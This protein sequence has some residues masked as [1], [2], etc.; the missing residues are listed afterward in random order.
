M[1]YAGVNR[2]ILKAAVNELD[3]SHYTLFIGLCFK[4]FRKSPF[5][6]EKKVGK[7]PRI[8]LFILE[9]PRREPGDV[10]ALQQ[11][12]KFVGELCNA[13]VLRVGLIAAAQLHAARAHRREKA[14][15]VLHAQNE[16][17]APRRLLE[18]LQRRVLR[19]FVHGVGPL[20]DIY[21]FGGLVGQD[22]SVRAHIADLAY[23]DL[24]FPDTLVVSEL[25]HQRQIRMNPGFYLAA[26]PAHAAGPV[27]RAAAQHLR[28]QLIGFFKPRLLRCRGHYIGV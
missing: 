20:D 11:F 7:Q 23:E 21:L 28:R 26:V 18:K 27:P 8:H 5:Y 25:G 6:S 17:N 16:V 13:L 14:R 1:F 22:V 15:R 3:I 10:A 12:D 24:L 4:L 19:L 9:A 2:L